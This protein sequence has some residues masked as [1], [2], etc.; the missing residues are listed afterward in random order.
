M[1]QVPIT[2]GNKTAREKFCSRP[3][4]CLCRKKYVFL[5]CVLLYI[6]LSLSIWMIL[7]LPLW[8]SLFCRLYSCCVW[9]IADK[10]FPSKRR[11]LF[12]TW[13][14]DTNGH[15]FSRNEVWSW[16][17]TVGFRIKMCWENLQKTNGVFK[18]ESPP[19][20]Y[21]IYYKQF[22]S[23]EE[24]FLMNVYSNLF[25]V[26]ILHRIKSNSTFGLGFSVSVMC[27]IFNSNSFPISRFC[28]LSCPSDHLQLLKNVMTLEAS[29]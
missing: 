6:P 26:A 5:C 27:L 11:Q 4:I 9:L 16:T 18:G 24:S 15:A 17:C 1:K 3:K 7:S 22:I 23:R 20:L 19:N 25:G 29:M 13:I 12:S 14:V 21:I 2:Q 28:F 10:I 8:C